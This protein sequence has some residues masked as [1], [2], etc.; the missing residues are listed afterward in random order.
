MRLPV[1]LRAP[2]LLRLSLS[3]AL[4]L[5]VAP[6]FAQDD[7]EFDVLDDDP[8]ARAPVYD[9]EDEDE[10]DDADDVDDVD[11]L[12]EGG[13]ASFTDESDL[14]TI[15]VVQSKPRLV[16]G[17]FEIAPQL[18]VSVNDRFTSHTGLILSGI[19]HLQEN[20]AVEVSVGGFFWWDDPF[21]PNA[22]GP[23]LGGRDTDMTI[24]IRQKERLAPE[25]VQLYRLTWLTTADL[26]WSPIYGKVS[27]H[28]WQLGQFNLYLSVGAGVTGLQLENQQALGD[29]YQ[30]DGPLGPEIGPMSL[31][32]TFGGGL[33][34]YFGEYF[35]V[36]FELRD[37]VNALQVLQTEVTSEAFS[38][39][40]VTN[41]LLAQVGVSFIF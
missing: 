27:V 10:E 25:L 36:R 22:P 21:G 40:D 41:T 26:Q 13:A 23:R 11:D 20:V 28:D 33:R 31:T 35:G 4:L 8:P 7:D 12:D 15:F 32:T 30:L 16:A 1:S 2:L 18:A 24:E 29:F 37:Y 3:L 34:F 6:A 17:S 38:T 19:Y 5:G 9:D 39:F 14:Q